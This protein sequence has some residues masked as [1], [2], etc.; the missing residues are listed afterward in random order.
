MNFAILAATVKIKESK[1]I[2]KYLDLTWGLK[3]LWNMRGTVIIIVG[4]PLKIILYSYADSGWTQ[5][6]NEDDEQHS[7]LEKYVPLTLLK[8]FE[9]GYSRFFCERELETKQNWNILTPTL[10]AISVV[11]FSF[12]R[13]V[14]GGLGASFSGCWLPLPYLVSNSSDLR[15]TDFLSSLCYIIVQLPTQSLEWHVWSSSSGNNCHAVHR[16]LSSGAS[17]CE[18]TVRF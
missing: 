5:R 8:G 9:K 1:K 10:M 13:A 18:C 3:K 4:D 15:L 7:L 17:V 16:S 14:P 12:S 6:H 2:H 11:S